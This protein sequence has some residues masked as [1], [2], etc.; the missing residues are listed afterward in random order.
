MGFTAVQLG[1]GGDPAPLAAAGLGFYLDQP[2]GKGVL[3]LRDSEWQPVAT[4]YERSRDPAGLIRP[5]CYV[6]VARRTAAVAG[7][8]AEVARVRG[9]GLRFV[10][11]ADEASAT[12]HD[13]PLDTCRCEPCLASW[14]AFVR[15]RF[16]TVEAANE[17]FGSQWVDFA[18]A[19]PL[20]TDQVRRREL[21]DNALPRDLRPFALRAEWVDAQF[22]DAVHAIAAAAR[23][24]AP[25]VPVGLTGLPAP[26]A[27]GGHD[28]AQL[29]APLSLVEAYPVGGADELVRWFAAPGAHRHA[30][31]APPAPGDLAGLS[32]A[33]FVRARLAAMACRGEAGVVVWND[34]TVWRNGERTPFGDAVQAGLQALATPLE[35]CAGATLLPAS[36]WLV[37]SQPSVRGW[38]MLDS[39]N[40]GMTW[41]RRLSSYES[42]HSTSQAARVG[43]LR[44]L[45]DLGLQPEFVAAATLPERLLRERP[46]CLVL[47]AILA[48]ADRTTQ[49]IVNYV[50]QGGTLLA[51][52]STGIYDEVLR[53]REF[54]A[55]DGVF[56]IGSRSLAWADQ[57]VREGTCAAAG[58][59]LPLAERGLVGKLG[60]RREGG[61][62]YLEQALG[63]GRATYLNAP[64]VMYP[65][66]RLDPAVHGLARELRKRVRAVLQRAGVEPPCDV[67]G[68]GLPT[69]LERTVLRTRTGAK[70]MAIRLHALE[71][72]AVLQQVVQRGPCPILL[73]WPRPHRLRRLGGEDLGTAARFELMLD[74]CGALFLEVLD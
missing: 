14:R 48:L 3:E 23:A 25:E 65:R 39:A 22:A 18:T 34:G 44:L 41:V 63:R 74:P 61:F 5:G 19:V 26:A 33:D 49:A 21:G 12:R 2:I 46:R 66:W 31:L 37:E 13:A 35:R 57:M 32:L 47:P 59:T 11:L 50:Q 40:D 51:D 38:W 10:A 64:V 36:V 72:P 58:G 52:H 70:V 17:A 43:W 53:R 4:A 42:T 8:A 20:S 1:R 45:Q 56:G 24:V 73:E 16:A 9:P 7:A 67:R 69:C 28:Y 29:L 60:E 6:E 15:Q 62:C 30:T 71:A 27:F 68:D 54:G 55:L